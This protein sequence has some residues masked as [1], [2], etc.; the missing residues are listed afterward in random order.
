MSEGE[1]LVEVGSSYLPTYMDTVRVEGIAP[2][3]INSLIGDLVCANRA[4]GSINLSIEGGAKPYQISWSNG[5]TS[6]NVQNLE[7]GIYSVT[8]KDAYN[9]P[10]GSYQYEVAGNE[11]I[12]VLSDVVDA[13]CYGAETGAIGTYA[14]G[15]VYPYTYKWSNGVDARVNSGVGAGNYDLLVTD[16]VGC[17]QDFQF[18]VDQ[19]E[20]LDFY[21]NQGDAV[22]EMGQSLTF[23]VSSTEVTQITWLKNGAAVSTGNQWIGSF[24]EP[25]VFEIAAIGSK[26]GC[27][28]QRLAII[29]VEDA[30]GI[31][32]ANVND[33][34]LYENNG[35]VVIEL[36]DSESEIRVV[37]YDLTGKTV[38]QTVK[39]NTNELR[40]QS[41][42][43]AGV[44]VVHITIGDKVLVKKI[45]IQ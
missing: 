3:E 22:I 1:Y 11:E 39:K 38:A 42:A 33:V 4:E 28:V 7:K 37:M 36:V 29:T 26:D 27:E 10:L 30:N 20:E 5:M 15:G 44:Y 41:P 18:S 40:M 24:E 9:C 14:E 6:T 2:A 45:E 16:A 25:G 23:Q 35:S 31:Q 34:K 43:V 8:I 19:P 17:V 12:T 21:L 32:S 13:S